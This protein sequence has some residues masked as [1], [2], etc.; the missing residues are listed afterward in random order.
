MIFTKDKQFY[1]S[2]IAL[3][4]PMILQNLITYS[5]GLADNLMIGSLGDSAVSGVYLGNQIQVVIQVLSAGIE[6]TVLLISSQYWGKGDTGAIRRIISIALRF[7]LGL[8]AV[9]NLVCAAAP[10]FVL[11][12]FTPDTRV[13]ESGAEYL[14]I[15]CFSFVFFCLTQSLIAAMRS[16]EST[17]IGML[18]S[19]SS[20][21]IDVA[22]NYVLI[23]GKLGLPA[24][25]VRGA[26]IAT[27]IA[28]IA[29][30]AIIVCY[31]LFVD[32]KLLFRPHHLKTVDR[33]LLRDMIR[34]GTPLVLGQLVWG[35]NLT[36]NSIILGHFSEA[37]ITGTSLANTANNLMYVAMNG[38]SGA[39]GIIIGKTV[40]SGNLSRIREYA[41]TVQLLLLSLGI[42]TSF[43]FWGIRDPF[44][45]LYDISPESADYARQFINVLRV[46]C[47]G[48][49][50]Q[51]GSLFGIVK[52]G[53]DV[54]FVFK[55]DTVHVFGIVIPSAIIAASLGG[56]PWIVFACLKADQ[57]LKCF[58]A[59]VKIQKYNW[60]KNLTRDNTVIEQ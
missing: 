43:V 16:V 60:M 2:L 51:A 55:N 44:I 59:F 34:Y 52:S 6:A 26:A 45:S 11:R 4:I 54:S 22:L 33:A 47:I 25:G 37:V 36:A 29:E 24:L 20:L 32:K 35:T 14:S 50:Y 41:R 5:V 40:G 23:F 13:I 56:A 8:G 39:V 49:C 17:Q 46:T 57:I 53:G 12:L 10:R 27:L 30:S 3:A 19:L 15:L 48:S 7:S 18:V 21:V 42:V 58:V 38:V 9:L 1:R 31:V 28:R